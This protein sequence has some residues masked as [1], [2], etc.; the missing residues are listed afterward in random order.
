VD[1]LDYGGKLLMVKSV[2][3]SVPI[4]FMACLD[5]PVSIK[6]QLVKYMRYYLWRKKNTE[7]QSRGPALI[8]WG[9]NCR[10]QDQGGLGVLNLHI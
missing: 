3:A 8:A 2:L 4:S 9:K 1:F 7:F 6:D 10:P 5:I